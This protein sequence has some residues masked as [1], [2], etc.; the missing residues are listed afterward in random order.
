MLDV[1]IKPIN[2]EDI[3]F[4]II[5]N[6]GD[7]KINAPGIDNFILSDSA[8]SSVYHQ[9]R[10]LLSFFK[11]TP[12]IFYWEILI[13]KI[14]DQVISISPAY[15][16]NQDF[17][18]KF[19]VY[20]LYKNKLKALKF[21]GGKIS[22]RE[23]LDDESRC[24]IINQHIST[25]NNSFDLAYLEAIHH[26]DF[27]FEYF[28]EKDKFIPKPTALDPGIVHLIDFP[29]SWDIYL[30]SMTKKRR[31]NLKRNIRILRDEFNDRVSFKTYQSSDDVAVF[32][33]Y[34]DQIYNKTWQSKTM[35]NRKRSGTPDQVFDQEI[36]RCGSFLSYIL[37][38]ENS[39]VAFVRGYLHKGEYN[40][41]EIGFDQ[42]WSKYNVGNVLNMMMLEDLMRLPLAVNLLNFGYG[43]NVYKQVFG[44][45]KFFVFNIYFYK[46]RS[47]A[48]FILLQSRFFNSLYVIC[49]KIIEV[50]NLTHFVRKIV[51]NK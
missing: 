15:I 12:S 23:D 32:Y 31:Y 9:S 1:Q 49:K 24:H 47:K 33:E 22:F 45:R 3:N 37:F 11:N 51:K 10:Y 27:L 25:I 46:A 16:Q 43:D 21:V 28:K 26:D 48:S 14:N 34:L 19:S 30:T 17:P 35:G 6:S 29:N 41:E 44:N 38:V 39:A 13:A 7:L 20:N 5:K 2:R 36:S 40:F 18:I 42:D 8:N 50:S 4:S